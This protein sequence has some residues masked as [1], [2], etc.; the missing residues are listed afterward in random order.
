MTR[1]IRPIRARNGEPATVSLERRL[2]GL[3][4]D[5]PDRRV[6]VKLVARRYRGAGV[7]DETSA[8]VTIPAGKRLQLPAGMWKSLPDMEPEVI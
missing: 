3:Q 2:D 7:V 1:R 8:S 4:L 6:A 5:V